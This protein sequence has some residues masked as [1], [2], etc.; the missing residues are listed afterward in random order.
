MGQKQGMWLKFVHMHSGRDKDMSQSK[1]SKSLGD[2][3]KYTKM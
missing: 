1:I 2:I 3:A